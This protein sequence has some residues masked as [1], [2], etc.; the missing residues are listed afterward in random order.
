MTNSEARLENASHAAAHEKHFQ[1]ADLHYSHW[2]GTFLLRISLAFSPENQFLLTQGGSSNS[3]GGLSGNNS[4]GGGNN[5]SV[6]KQ[7][8]SGYPMQ[9]IRLGLEH[10]NLSC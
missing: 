7:S 1:H 5:A 9:K 2:A 3:S 6:G 10:G 4:S 8:S